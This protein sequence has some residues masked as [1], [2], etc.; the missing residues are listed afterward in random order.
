MFEVV[1]A[2]G[3]GELVE[4]GATEFPEF[5]DGSFRAVAEQFLE[6]GERQL[7]RIQIRRV[8]R[9]V[10]QLGMARPQ[11]SVGLANPRDF[12][13]LERLS[14]TTRSPGFKTEGQMLL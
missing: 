7:D 14:I 3:F 5:V 2:L 12:M 13:K 1:S 9:Q 6:L 4:D 10:T 11:L 8:G